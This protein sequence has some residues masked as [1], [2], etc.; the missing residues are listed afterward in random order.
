[1][2]VHI[3]SIEPA[4]LDAFFALSE[5]D[6]ADRGLRRRLQSAWDDGH[7]SPDL[8]FLAEVAGRPVGRLAYTTGP[9]ASTLPDVSEATLLA[10]WLPWHSP[11]A[12]EIGRRL[13]VDTIP[14]LAP[15]VRWVDGS[16]NPEYMRGAHVRRL[17]F[18]AAGLPLF[19]EKEGFRWT[20]DAD[21]AAAVAA[22]RWAF[23][24]LPEA[25]ADA[26]LEPMARALEGTLDRQDRHYAD[27]TGADGWAR[28]MLGYLTDED[29]SGWLLARDRSGAAAGYVLVGEF[30]RPTRGSILHIGVVP[31]AR[32]QGL[33]TELLRAANRAAI[34]RGYEEM[35]SD[36][37]VRNPPMLAAM[38]RAG[39][40][41]SATPWHVW[42]HRLDL[43]G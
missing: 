41:A 43:R 12:V 16:A 37:D 40:L 29:A 20:P 30:D 2:D 36:V 1:M 27:L 9:V 10:M 7:G 25:G 23:Q 31:E 5:G 22:D 42:H 18:E 24:P 17:V 14:R 39:H 21:Q 13:I 28:E 3:R 6:P 34:A 35:I 11:N 32:G 19:Q 4:E 15:A 8:T 38:E 26:F 33:V